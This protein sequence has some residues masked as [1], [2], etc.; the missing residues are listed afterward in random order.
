MKKISIL[1]LHLGYGGIE[2]A[3]V[4]LANSLCTKY[5]VEIACTYKLY[6]KPAFSLK[7]GVKIKYLTTVKPNKDTLK[8]SLK[9]K[10]IFKFFKELLYSIKVLYLRK[11]TM[12]N[13]IM[14]SDSNVIISTRDIFNFWLSKYGSKNALKIG[15]EHN[16]YHNNMKYAKKIVKS[17]YH[18]HYFVLVSENLKNYYEKE[19]LSSKCRCV[20]IPNSIE[21]IPK[22]KSLLDNK[23]LVAVGRLSYEKGFLDLL[24]VFKLLYEKDSSYTLDIVGDGTEKNVLEKFIIDNHLDNNVTLH[25]F[26]GREYINKLLC[27]SSLY[28]M[29]SYT[30]S[31]GIVLIEAMSFGLPCIAFDSAEGACEVIDDDYNGYLIENRDFDLMVE[32]IEYLILDDKKRISMGKNAALSV[33]KYTSDVV[34]KEW[35]N[36]IEESDFNE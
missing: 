13:Y 33:K 25:G 12:I 14:N 10:N 17:V 29:S 23:A 8:E 24:K 15:W 21:S 3:V 31:F 26:Q 27:K 34:K 11:K 19:L 4:N 16:H 30:E 1:S 32:K 2:K 28:L 5:D 18:L 6:D 9:C 35:V 7:P 22:N 36:L 20:F